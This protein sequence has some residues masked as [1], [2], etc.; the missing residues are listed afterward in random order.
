MLTD[1]LKCKAL[2]VGFIFFFICIFGTSVSFAANVTFSWTPPS[3]NS[4]GTPLTDLAGYRVY[5]GV[6]SGNYT[7][8][9]DAGNVTSYTV[10]NLSVGSTYYFAVTA[11][12]TS[13][14]QS[15]FSN[16]ISRTI[17]AV[18]Y[19]CDKDKDG[20][21]N[22]TVD[23]T[24]A[25]TGC[26]PAGCRDTAGN[27]CNDN[28][29]NINPGRSDTTCNG[30]D[31]N[32]NG[33][34]DEG[35]VTTESNCGLGV[36]SAT[37][38]NICQNGTIVNTCTPGH[39][40]GADDNCN[41]IDE[42]C[43]GIADDNYAAITT[44]CGLGACASTGVQQCI[45][46]QLAD[47]CTPHTAAIEECD[48]LDNNC[49]GQVD[50]G[51]DSGISG[52]KISKVIL[53]EDFANGV[54]E[55]WTTSG[56][57]NTEDSC[58]RNIEGFFVSPYAIVD[59]SC[60][61]AGTAELVS[62]PLDTGFC[63]NAQLAFSNQYDHNAGNVEVDVSNDGGISWINSLNM[64]SDDG[65]PAANWK[66]IDLSGI[67]GV[68]NAV[69]K[70]KDSDSSGDG[71]WALDNIWATCQPDQL[72]FSGQVQIPSAAQTVM[73]SNTGESNLTINA[74][75]TDGVDASAFI[76]DSG[77]NTCSGMTL[78]PSESCTVDVVFLPADTGSKSAAL[79]IASNDQ[80]KPRWNIPLSGISS[81]VDPAPVLKA[82][83]SRGSLTVK[84][85][86]NVKLQYE[87]DPGSY[88][89]TNA[90]WWVVQ[91]Y[92]GS[93]T[94]YSAASPKKR[95]VVS[96]YYQGPLLKQ[97]PVKIFK[98]KKLKKGQHTFYF[99]VDT[100]MNGVLDPEEF[101]YDSVTVNVK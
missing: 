57:W 41:G 44:S 63:S 20:Y 83:K 84:K 2:C 16:E 100:E 89:N 1:Y 45:S 11:Y 80:L 95:E 64:T 30:I 76:I 12:D 31:D 94:Y 8:N 66:Y 70:F 18:N 36:C 27:D 56:S 73:I 13:G 81:V 50:E 35:Y 90:D 15:S 17:T 77:T 33:Q 26:E 38:Q 14:N 86:K 74:I 68:K 34:V 87:L 79:V 47:T 60:T 10:N 67:S 22:I 71:Y 97:G 99:G 37:G 88:E 39:S 46:G 48:G 65:Y 49:D 3:T 72:E 5:S 58:G 82:N 25:G 96:L 69:I 91:E 42:N 53:K 21:I 9:T 28:N 78:S 85:G 29:I 92:N 62:P 93:L 4:D 61:N 32:C 54:Q 23:G 52:I 40:T 43:N 75:G 7:Q 6:S 59:P 51:C 55:T 19:Y 101:Y 24:C 98:S